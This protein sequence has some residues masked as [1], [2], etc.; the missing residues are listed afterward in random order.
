MSMVVLTSNPSTQVDVVEDQD[1]EFKASLGYS[2]SYSLGCTLRPYLNNNNKT[3]GD[4]MTN[5]KFK[6]IIK[7]V[8]LTTRILGYKIK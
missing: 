5:N 2:V 8:D 7:K 1:W 3:N 6:I 4:K